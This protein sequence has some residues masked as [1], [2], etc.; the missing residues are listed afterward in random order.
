M[1]DYTLVSNIVSNIVSSI[2]SNIVSNI[3]YSIVY[4]MGR[5]GEGGSFSCCSSLF[6]KGEKGHLLTLR[7]HLP[8]H[9]FGG[10]TFLLKNYA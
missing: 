3:V 1:V 10:D 6:M 9:N 4:S 8:F 5:T 7:R 2:V